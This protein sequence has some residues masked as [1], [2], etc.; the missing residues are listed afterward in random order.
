MRLP[1]DLR[2]GVI[3]RIRYR[4]NYVNAETYTL[5]LWAASETGDYESALHLLWE[6][7]AAQADDTEYTLDATDFGEIP[8][9]LR[10]AGRIYFSVE[11]TGAPG[12]IQGFIRV[13]GI[14]Y[15]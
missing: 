3:K 12:N 5:R 8:F 4:L 14:E 6:S 7:P 13:D 9:I 1:D 10:R 2:R 15:L 11:W